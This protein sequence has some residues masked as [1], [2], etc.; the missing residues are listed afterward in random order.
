MQ[1]GVSESLAVASGNTASLCALVFF[2]RMTARITA[3]QSQRNWIRVPPAHEAALVVAVTGDIGSPFGVGPPGLTL[4]VPLDPGQNG[5]GTQLSRRTEP[6]RNVRRGNS[7]PRAVSPKHSLS[8]RL[9][10]R[11]NAHLVAGVAGT[12]SRTR[13]DS[14][15]AARLADGER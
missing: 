11:R 5:P 6:Q 14:S 7:D 12:A 9:D 15:S 1:T 8:G 10:R 4:R 13:P 3:L 2:V